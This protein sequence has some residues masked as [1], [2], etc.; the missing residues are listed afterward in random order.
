VSVQ[1]RALAD[2]VFEA[3]AALDLVVQS[4]VR[5]VPSLTAPGLTNQTE[6]PMVQVFTP[7]A[8][9][10]PS[11]LAGEGQAGGLS[12]LPVRDEEGWAAFVGVISAEA[13]EQARSDDTTVQLINLYRWRAANTPHRFYL[14]KDG[15][16]AVA[17]VG[18]FQHRTTAYLH[19]LFTHPDFRRRG[20]GSFLTQAM[21]A[22]ARAV[23]CE[24]VALLCTRESGLPAYFERLGFRVVGERS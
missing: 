8:G 11:P 23:G 16:H 22:E 1:L 3:A 6:L 13:V 2:E 5:S 19:G 17:C 15:D 18:L 24:R 10:L 20:A 7:D 21:E 14:A 12:I 9:L 4:G